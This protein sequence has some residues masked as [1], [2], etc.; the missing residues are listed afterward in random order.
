MMQLLYSLII[1]ISMTS[2][3][4]GNIKTSTEIAESYK[5]SLKKYK[6]IQK[7]LKSLES[8][9]ESRNNEYL[10]NIKESENRITQIKKVNE[11]LTPLKTELQKSQNQLKRVVQRILINQADNNLSPEISLENKILLLSARKKLEEKQ[12]LS[13]KINKLQKK[14][15]HLEEEFQSLR[16]NQFTV[17]DILKELES[18]KVSLSTQFIEVRKKKNS[19][20]SQIEKIKLKKQKE[21]RKSSGKTVFK[22]RSPLDQ[23]SKSSFDKKGITFE[24]QENTPVYSSGDGVVSYVGRLANYGK[25]VMIDHGNQIRSVYL[26][27]FSPK[28]RKGKKLSKGEV[29]GYTQLIRNQ[30]TNLYFEVRKKDIAQKTIDWI[31]GNS[32]KLASNQK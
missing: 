32:I 2:I 30:K 28:V 11:V 31:D 13:L 3:A 26:G 22:L 20:L 9:L 1:T 12:S 27:H 24:V 5:S 15:S 19:Y 7:Q 16:K 21:R 4:L 23:F 8:S 18:K 29:L 6:S 17:L 14:F 10:E 25:I